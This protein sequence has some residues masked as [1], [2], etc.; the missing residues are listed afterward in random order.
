MNTP[1]LKRILHV[2]DDPAIR[3]VV[4]LALGRLGGYEVQSADSADAALLC[5]EQFAPQ[6]LLLDVMMPSIDGPMLLA[7][8]RARVD[9]AHVPAIFMTAKASNAEHAALMAHGA[10]AIIEKP[11]DPM[12]LSQ[13]VAE[14][15]QNAT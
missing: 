10:C 12:T 7:M 9:T 14:H 8:L 13:L 1:T 6:L 5:V 3:K 15:W 2:E 4:Q 11:F